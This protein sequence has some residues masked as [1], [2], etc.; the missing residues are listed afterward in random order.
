MED[1]F[2]KMAV[3][4]APEPAL[5]TLD[6]EILSG[7]AGGMNLIEIP[8]RAYWRLLRLLGAERYSWNSQYESGVWSSGRRSPQ[9]VALVAELCRGGR[10][11]EFGC[12][13]GELP[14]LLPAGSFSDYLGID[15]A[16]VAVACA[17]QRAAE[18][19]LEGCRFEQAD[20]TKW[21]AATGISVILAE[22]CLYYLKPEQIEV[23]LD[24]SCA[25]LVPEGK[26]V[27]IVHSAAKHAAT[28]EVCRRVCR[29]VNEQQHGGRAYLI[30]ER[31]V[32]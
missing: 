18:A 25:S 13:E 7:R 17:R 26:I 28:L 20:M 30:L 27:V 9:T 1:I 8:K 3:D 19:R 2:S 31:R 10:L 6:K 16:D 11:I 29:V 15:I 21:Q 14:H 23:F 5:R 12:G 32:G 24:H 4:F 22:E